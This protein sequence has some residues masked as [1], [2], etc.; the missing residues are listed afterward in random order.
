MSRC[1][2]TFILSNFVLT[3]HRLCP[4][5]TIHQLYKHINIVTSRKLCCRKDISGSNEPLQRYRHSKLFKMATCRELGFDVTGNSA[6]RSA[7]PENPTIEPNMKCIGSPVAEIWPFAYLA[8][9]W[10]P[11]MRRRGG[12]RGLAMAPFKKAMVVSD[13][14]SIVTVALSVTIQPQF[15]IECL[16]RS[17]HRGVGNFGPKYP[18]VPLGVDP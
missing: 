12:R 1:T 17:N 11:I 2:N 14:L 4:I 13:R 16:R 18:G 5:Y 15:A 3:M 6:I 8:G 9:I 10:N 7:D